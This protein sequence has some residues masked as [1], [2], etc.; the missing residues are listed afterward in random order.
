MAFAR[1][2]APRSLT[3][4]FFSNCPGKRAGSQPRP[5]ILQRRE[6]SGF[7][8][9]NQD[10]S[11]DLSQLRGYRPTDRTLGYEPKDESSNLSNR[12]IL[13]GLRC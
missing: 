11:N 1:V 2:C 10:L 7:Y 6:P 5:A 13:N 9:T 8:Q 12:T 4:H 3:A